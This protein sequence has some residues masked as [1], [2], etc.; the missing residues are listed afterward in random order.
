M[1][2]IILLLGFASTLFITSCLPDSPD[3]PDIVITFCDLVTTLDENGVKDIVNVYFDSLEYTIDDETIEGK[4]A[5]IEGF[6]LW[7]KSHDCIEETEI[8]C[9]ACIETFP[10]QSEVKIGFKHGGNLVHRTMDL[11][12]STPIRFLRWHE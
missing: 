12:M 10:E 2:K 8:I 3:N 4:T 5:N 6:E 9:V 1:Q 7:L 11:E